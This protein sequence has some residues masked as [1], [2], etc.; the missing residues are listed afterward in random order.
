MYKN[1]Q[2]THCVR[3][4]HFDLSQESAFFKQLSVKIHC[5]VRKQY[6]L[7]IVK[8]QKDIAMR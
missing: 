6:Y 2:K 5:C 7:C 1:E 8:R 3:T 4:Q